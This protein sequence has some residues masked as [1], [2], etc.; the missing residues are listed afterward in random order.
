MEEIAEDSLGAAEEAEELEPLLPGLETQEESKAK[1][2]AKEINK[3][4]V[5]MPYRINEKE[6]PIN[7]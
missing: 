7:V 1:E 3:V 5:F 2:A 6:R 4:L